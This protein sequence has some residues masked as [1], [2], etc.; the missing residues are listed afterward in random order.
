MLNTDLSELNNGLHQYNY[1]S[2]GTKTC[3]PQ[4]TVGLFTKTFEKQTL[5][6]LN[7][8]F[9][10]INLPV[11]KTIHA[12][13]NIYGNTQSIQLERFVHNPLSWDAN[14]NEE[15]TYCGV[16]AEGS[17]LTISAY[18]M[19]TTEDVTVEAH[20]YSNFEK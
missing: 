8:N 14:I 3:P 7:I 16:V 9:A 19:D 17:T 5:V 6:A 15:L 4:E 10:A 11:G 2:D 1:I 12:K 13:I 18:G 20:L